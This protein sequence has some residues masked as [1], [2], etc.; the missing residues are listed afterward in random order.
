MDKKGTKQEQK[1]IEIRNFVSENPI[2][3]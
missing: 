2:M 1:K 3:K